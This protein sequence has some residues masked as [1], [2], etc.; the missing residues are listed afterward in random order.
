MPQDKR[1]LA[2]KILMANT[3]ILTLGAIAAWSGWIPV[4]ESN[5]PMLAAAFAACAIFDAILVS[6]LVLRS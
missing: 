3:A 5:R 2:V 4:A 6:V 1:G